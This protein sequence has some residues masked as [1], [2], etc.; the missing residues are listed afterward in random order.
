MNDSASFAAEE[1]LRTP[2]RNVQL[3]ARILDL[4]ITSGLSRQ[5]IRRAI[6]AVDFLIS[7]LYPCPLSATPTSDQENDEFRQ[8][9]DL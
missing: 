4:V 8:L 9:H 2:Y 3:T 7:G 5:E 1:L 6:G